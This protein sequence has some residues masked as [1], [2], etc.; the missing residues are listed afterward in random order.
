MPDNVLQNDV[1]I[2]SHRLVEI[3]I[4]TATPRE[5]L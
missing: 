3:G 4:N 2:G 1:A 5:G